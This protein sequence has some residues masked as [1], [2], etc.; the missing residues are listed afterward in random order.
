VRALRN[1]SRRVDPSATRRKA[2]AS[3]GMTEQSF[4]APIAVILSE[5]IQGAAESARPGLKSFAE[6]K[7]LLE[8]IHGL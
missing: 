3:V 2:A 4:S 5:A 6:S 8:A 1:E 7:D